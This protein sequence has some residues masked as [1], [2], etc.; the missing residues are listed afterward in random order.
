MNPVS[1]EKTPHRRLRAGRIE[2]IPPG[3]KKFLPDY[4]ENILVVNV[5]GQFFA[6]SNTCPHAG[7]WMAY[8]PLDGYILECPMH[9]WP[10]D[11]RNGCLA[12]M[13]DSGLFERLNT[14]AVTVEAGEVFVE[15][16]P[17]A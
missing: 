15:L 9:Y 11:V 12:G 6:V 7:G 10:F 13:E 1:T 16:P 14:Y 3:S 4:Y 5:D 2:D 8:G 17:G